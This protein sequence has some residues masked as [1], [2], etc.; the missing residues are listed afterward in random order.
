M[1][2]GFTLIELMI[3]VAIIGV[4]AAIALP[5]YQ[6]YVAR[7]QITS[8]IAELN[9]ARTQYELVMNDGA[10]SSAFTTDNM[11][12]SAPDSQFCHYLVHAPD[13]GGVSEPALE[14]Q[15][16]NVATVLLGK[17]IYLNRQANGSWRCSVSVGISNSLKP[18]DCT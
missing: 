4:L 6:N 12:F 17:S 13:A 11:G 3:V 1:N 5:L 2:K 14:C 9:G 10:N 7:S 16:H 8:A 18:V 15:M